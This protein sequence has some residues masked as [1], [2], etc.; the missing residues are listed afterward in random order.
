MG[1]R[2]CRGSVLCKG[3]ICAFF[4]KL[5]HDFESLICYGLVAGMLPLHQKAMCK[6]SEERLVGE[7]NCS[8]KIA[9]PI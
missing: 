8:K 7:S 4:S 2:V 9:S 1:D 6:V 5:L 3:C